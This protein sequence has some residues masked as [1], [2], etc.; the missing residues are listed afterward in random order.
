MQEKYETKQLKQTA[1]KYKV[2][3]N[4]IIHKNVQ[5]TKELLK[6]RK[7]NKLLKFYKLIIRVA[8]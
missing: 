5:P 3:P 2:N 4:Q 6:N 8:N 7:I 1:A